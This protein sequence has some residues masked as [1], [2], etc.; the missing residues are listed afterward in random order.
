MRYDR[1]TELR[2]AFG[3][4][5]EKLYVLK[6]HIGQV[7]TAIESS[8]FPSS[9]MVE[10]LKGMLSDYSEQSSKL[11]SLGAELAIELDGSFADVE[12]NIDHAIETERSASVRV[13]VLDYFKLTAE[14]EDIRKELEASKERL[15]EKCREASDNTEFITPYR[16]VLKNVRSGDEMLEEDYDVIEK[17]LGRKIVR[18]VDKEKVRFDEDFDISGYLDGSCELLQGF[19]PDDNN[20][21]SEE[22]PTNDIEA[23]SESLDKDNPNIGEDRMEKDASEHG[24]S[25]SEESIS[26]EGK[27]DNADDSAEKEEANETPE[28]IEIASEW[29]SFNGYAHNIEIDYRD[30]PAKELGAKSFISMCKQKK[31]ALLNGLLSYSHRIFI[32]SDDLATD[33]EPAATPSQEMRDYLNNHGFLTTIT[34]KNDGSERAFDMLTSKSWECYSKSDVVRFFRQIDFPHIVPEPL[35]LRPSYITPEVALRLEMIH[36]YYCD[37]NEK[38]NYVVFSDYPGRFI[39]ANGLDESTSETIVCAAIFEKGKEADDIATLKSII[40]DA[41]DGKKIIILVA[42]ISDVS[43]ISDALALP[44]EYQT[45]VKYC[46]NGSKNELYDYEGNVATS[47]KEHEDGDREDVDTSVEEEAQA[48]DGKEDE[49]R[50]GINASEQHDTKENGDIAAE[51]VSQLEGSGSDDLAEIKKYETLGRELITEGKLPEALMMF[52]A[53][54]A[55]SDIDAQYYS[56][57]AFALDDPA[58]PKKYKY[59]ELQEVFSDQYGDGSY[60]SL[61]L[62][63]YLRMFFSEDAREEAYY[64]QNCTNALSENSLYAGTPQLK[65]C[66]FTLTEMFEKTKKGFDPNVINSLLNEDGIKRRIAKYSDD[67][68]SIIESRPEETAIENYRVLSTRRKLF[69]NGSMFSELLHHVADNEGSYA[70]EV[71]EKTKTFLECNYEPGDEY[72]T[73]H[74]SDM[75]VEDYIDEIWDSLADKAKRQRADS[76]KG[77]GR[78]GIINR[79]KS[80]ITVC[81][82]WASLCEAS[83]IMRNTSAGSDRILS[84]STK[85]MAKMTEAVESLDGRTFEDEGTNAGV[86]V[87]KSTINELVDRLDG[88]Y[89]TFRDAFFYKSFLK[90]NFVEIGEDYMPYE[91]GGEEI[92]KFNLCKRIS[93]QGRMEDKSW[94]DVLKTIFEDKEQGLDFGHAKLIKDYLARTEPEFNWPANYDIA[95]NIETAKAELDSKYGDFLARLEMADNYGWVESSAIID[96]ITTDVERRRQHCIDSGNYG[97]YFRTMGAYVKM[98]EHNAELYK[99]PKEARLHTLRVNAGEEYPVF[100][101][102]E[103]L[104]NEH[105]YS[106]AQDYMDQVE[107]DGLKEIPESASL[108]EKNDTLSTFI[109]RYADYYRESK[110]ADQGNIAEKYKKRHRFEENS[111]YKTGA[112]MLEAWPR[113]AGNELSTADKIKSL[114]INMGLPVKTVRAQN[115]YHYLVTFIDRVITADFPHPIGAYGSEMLRDGINVFLLFG[116]KEAT[117]MN[118]AIRRLITSSVNGASVILSDTQISLS[119]KRKLARA[120]KQE[121][122]NISPYLIL[123]RVMLLHLANQPASER[124]NIFLKC[125][126]PFHYLNPFT[127]NSAVEICPDMFIGR[128]LELEQVMSNG[129]ANIICGGR[130]LGKTALLHHAKRLSDDRSSGQWSVYISIKPENAESAA[131]RIYEKLQDEGFLAKDKSVID[132]NGLARAI[133]NRINREEPKVTRF[134]LLIDEADNFLLDSQ[135]LEYMPI[136]RLKQIQDDTGNKFKFVL[137]GLHNVIKFHANTLDGNS[138]LAHLNTVTIKPLPYSEASRL[139]E[140]PLSYLGF[141]LKDDD[142]SLIAQILSSTNY[143]PGLIQFYAS[144]LVRSVCQGSYGDVNEKPP[145]LLE[146]SQIL[147]LLKDPEF[148]DNIR[149]KFMITLGID[150]KDKGYYN[151]IAH[152]LAYCYFENPDEAA[153][154]Y[155]AEQIYHVGEEFGI[156][157]ITEL[158]NAQINSLLEELRI[159]N[160]IRKDEQEDGARYIFNRTSFRHMLGDEEHV[161]DVLCEI[162]E[163]ENADEH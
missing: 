125:S 9:D 132:W 119:D 8:R 108:M 126:L 114:F 118:T 33:N 163:K 123:D 112:Q 104:I 113:S 76:L 111:L 142:I 116:T 58:Y 23:A 77:I 49:V 26:E 32:A 139:L 153:A 4:I 141:R 156:P 101:E 92:S 110:D 102:I 80:I 105:M 131:I 57:L 53:L 136:D 161:F 19:E 68:A 160:V 130:Q 94:G 28:Q 99:Q 22:A 67:A 129:G 157:S 122:Q 25:D 66:I 42:A 17:S 149:D 52:R 75:K 60:D 78:S 117:T 95:L 70:K 46:L 15:I 10:R 5:K 152:L 148:I 143:F 72:G 138:S 151:T 150:K 21:E 145:Y 36:D 39:R 50:A 59:T 103:R 14:A 3:E 47:P 79:M 40:E 133:S 89:D 154:G 48:N 16:T 73:E 144:R 44:E 69:G 162:S 54:S 65:E 61:A 96:K 27:A 87:L 91:D 155:S 120:I 31:D 85:I 128:R 24:E 140:R 97:F 20:E 34:I 41:G 135:K 6:D 147:K 159:L 90:G 121:N 71:G 137:A 74:L 81:L 158:K 38:Q 30:V 37:D 13:V 100:K 55:Y 106:V 51:D 124:W 35:R 11:Q 127:E 18:A 62:A 64:V 12:A 107:R 86:F 1:L 82:N 98:L 29:D 134:L 45:R 56:R 109:S 146:E 63:A 84:Y 115:K 88:N 2:T 7:A 43:I 83:T 93:E